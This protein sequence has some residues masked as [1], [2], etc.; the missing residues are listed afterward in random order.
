AALNN[1]DSDPE[2]GILLALE[3][4]AEARDAGLPVPREAQE[5]LHHSLQ[6]SRLEM[7]I[8]AHTS[9][10]REIKFSPDGERLVS[11]GKDRDLKIW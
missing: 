4:V 10:I 3:A 9:G 5:A 11:V 8:T 7:V 2:L 1:L 6:V